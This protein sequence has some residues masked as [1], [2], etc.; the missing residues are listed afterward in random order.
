MPYARDVRRHRA[1]ARLL[2]DRTEV[3]VARYRRDV[4]GFIAMQ[5]GA[6]QSLYLARPARGQGIGQHFLDLAKARADRL[7][8]WTYQANMAARRFYAR[9]GFYEHRLTNGEDNDQNL[10]DVHM[11]WSRG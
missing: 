6:V 2:I 10:P 9:Q 5:D 11:V 8:L 4:V 1:D 7:E 3:T